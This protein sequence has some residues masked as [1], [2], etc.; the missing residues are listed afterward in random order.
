[1]YVKS[2]QLLLMKAA[3]KFDKT[4]VT[5]PCYVLSMTCDIVVG[6]SYDVLL[7][8]ITLCI[9]FGCPFIISSWLGDYGLNY[10]F[11]KIHV[12]YFRTR[13][14]N[15]WSILFHD[16]KYPNSHFYDGQY[17]HNGKLQCYFIMIFS[18]ATYI[19]L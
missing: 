13:H 8:Y 6:S 16:N 18:T 1:M 9:M 19:V 5:D 14:K 12:A 7:P 3:I 10:L 2:V 4:S 15:I 11:N 17:H